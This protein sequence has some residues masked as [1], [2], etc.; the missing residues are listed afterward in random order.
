MLQ[1]SIGFI[2]CVQ[3]NENAMP[4]MSV[5]HA[6]YYKRFNEATV[7]LLSFHRSRQAKSVDE[8]LTGI[9]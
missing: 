3:T 4:D 6:Y 7:Y 1:E 9:L 8:Q 5:G 2:V